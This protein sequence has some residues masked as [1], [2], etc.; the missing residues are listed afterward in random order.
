MWLLQGLR[1]IF[2]DPM[3]RRPVQSAV[4][5]E[6][7]GVCRHAEWQQFVIKD[8]HRNT[9]DGKNT[10]ISGRMGVFWNL[11]GPW[12]KTL[13]KWHFAEPDHFYLLHLEFRK[14]R[15]RK[16]VGERLIFYGASASGAK[17]FAYIEGSNPHIHNMALGVLSLLT[18]GKAKS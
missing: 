14:G 6:S 4:V 5:T 17:G 2:A 9:S 10:Q 3:L 16:R 11:N 18:H 8:M 1:G 12:H 15:V 13:W 7:V